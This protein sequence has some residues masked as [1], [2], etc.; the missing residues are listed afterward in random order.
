MKKYYLFIALA[1]VAAMAVSCNNKNTNTDEANA[2]V[3]EAAKTILTDDV[4]ATL[5]ELAKPYIN[6]A[7]KVEADQII[8][9][10]LTKE[11]KLVKPDYLL[12]PKDVNTMITKSQKIKALAILILERDIRKAYEMS[13]DE[14]NETLAR[15]MIELNH[16]IQ[17]ENHEKMSV[18]EKAT[19]TYNQYKERGE[20]SLY[21]QFEF[22]LINEMV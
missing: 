19:E 5:D 9:A 1:M 4:L 18:L 14:I 13:V 8:A 22:A 11:E 2:E 10:N 20:L 3:V 12:N 15:L 21:W 17:L 7:G 6:G 16:P